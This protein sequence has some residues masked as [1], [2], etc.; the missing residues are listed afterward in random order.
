MNLLIKQFTFWI[1]TAIFLIFGIASIVYGLP[2][3]MND[4]RSSKAHLSE[5]DQQ[6]S[7][8]ENYLNQVNQ[9]KNSRSEIEQYYASATQALP[10]DTQTDTLLLQLEGLLADLKLTGSTITVPF[11]Q[12]ATAAASSGSEVKAGGAASSTTAPV[13]KTNTSQTTFTISGEMSFASLKTL[14]ERLRAFSRWNRITAI[15]F[16]QSAG[17]YTASVTAQVFWLATSPTEFS[18]STS[19]LSSAKTILSSLKSYATTPSV[20]T[21]GSYGRSDPFVSP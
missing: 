3:L 6:I 12:A 18:G 9:L 14:L 13:V 4:Y 5:L 11:T 7:A 16:T 17:T 8:K 20:T 2:P 10:A 19:F 15:D 1:V 21:E